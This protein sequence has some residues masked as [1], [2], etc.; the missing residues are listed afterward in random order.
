MSEIINGVR[1]FRNVRVGLRAQ[2]ARFDV[3]HLLRACTWP[4]VAATMQS[5]RGRADTRRARARARA[6]LTKDPT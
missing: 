6:T 3:R 2:T 5:G 1:A 4:A